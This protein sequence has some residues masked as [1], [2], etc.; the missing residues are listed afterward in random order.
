VHPPSVGSLLPNTEIHLT[1]LFT[2]PCCL[3]VVFNNDSSIIVGPVPVG[4]SGKRTD[5]G[6][7]WSAAT[8][9]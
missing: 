3:Q 5:N 8:C 9:E 4:C 6:A 2:L 7:P 1:S